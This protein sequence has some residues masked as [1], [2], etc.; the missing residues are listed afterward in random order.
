MDIPSN[1]NASGKCGNAK[2]IEQNI[3]L[4]WI[5]QSDSSLQNNFTLYFTKNEMDKHYSLDHLEISLVSK[6]LPDNKLS[7]NKHL[8]HKL[9]YS[10]I[11]CSFLRREVFISSDKTI[12]L[13]H[14]AVQFSVGLSNS[15][16][17]FKEQTLNL[18]LP[19]KNKT[20]GHLKISGLQ[21]QA[22]RSDNTTVFALGRCQYSLI[23]SNYYQYDIYCQN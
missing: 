6:E 17:C 15:Y 16:R 9:I 11:S 23:L 14:K 3:V 22:F 21:F 12:I 1:S 2:D 4:S 8:L 20:I 13:V 10:L 5:S 19:D 18:T 7:M